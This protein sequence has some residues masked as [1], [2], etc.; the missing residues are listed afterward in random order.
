M[1]VHF[2]SDFILAMIFKE[3]DT[4]PVIKHSKLEANMTSTV[5]GDVVWRSWIIKGVGYLMST[6]RIGI[7]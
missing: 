5:P 7:N 4:A 2:R 3:P 6:F 1:S